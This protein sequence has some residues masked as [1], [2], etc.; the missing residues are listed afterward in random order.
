MIEESN[1]KTV[2]KRMNLTLCHA[3]PTILIGLLC[4]KV[5]KVTRLDHT[6]SPDYDL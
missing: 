1:S 6:E 5:N 2:L 3:K 4:G